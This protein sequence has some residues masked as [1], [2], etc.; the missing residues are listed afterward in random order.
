MSRAED[1][2]D[3][4]EYVIGTL[5]PAETIV[6]ERMLEESTVARQDV[7]Y[8]QERLS[9]L[10]TH[11]DADEISPDLWA[12]IAAQLPDEVKSDGSDSNVVSLAEQRSK[13][14]ASTGS[15]ENL[16]PEI[17]SLQ[18]SRS[19]WR[20]M[21][22]AASLAAMCLG[23]F[24]IFDRLQDDQGTAGKF[25]AVVNA[26]GDQPALIVRVDGETGIVNVR[27]IGVQVPE[28]KSLELWHIPEG[29]A[30]VSIGLVDDGAD[31]LDPVKPEKGDLFAI[32]LEPKG[33]SPKSVATGE[34][35]YTGRL[36]EDVDSQ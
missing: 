29:Q 9:A 36:V 5:S 13:T 17:A 7:A 27:T 31:P 30:G 24:L 18:K 26:T 32:S 8:W 6:F 35:I 14:E 12:K 19:R 25:I 28:D 21:A 22:M 4:A 23:G 2:L 11:E 10:L 16:S 1:M 34:V 33:G 3:A 20:G 15:S